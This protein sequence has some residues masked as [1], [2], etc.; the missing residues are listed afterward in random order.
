MKW[1][2][3][4]GKNFDFVFS[5]KSRNLLLP[6]ESNSISWN[7]DSKLNEY[8][9]PNENK[10]YNWNINQINVCIILGTPLIK[11]AKKLL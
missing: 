9:S 8:N 2:I 10:I 6:D 3:Y 7:T 5:P 1:I 11:A 4:K